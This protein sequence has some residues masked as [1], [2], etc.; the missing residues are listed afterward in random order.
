MLGAVMLL[1]QEEHSG[2][3]L[4]LPATEELIW[5]AICFAIVAFLL[6]RFAFPRLRE[7]VEARENTIQKALED[8]E[9]SRD[10]AKKLLED[11]RKQLSEARSEA[12]RVIEESRRQGEEVRRDI[13]S[14]A[15]K[16]A[17]GIVARARDQIEAERN[18]TVQE[19]RGQIAQLSID[20]AEKVVGR[21][22]DGEAQRDLV[23]AYISEVGSMRGNGSGEGSR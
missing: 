1:A 23:D 15:E 11:Y 10:E 18:R 19:L 12:N 7:T 16:D 17:E 6:V 20:L 13:I 21:S 5:G 3:D 2:L 4:I 14:R 8:T 9:R 22:L